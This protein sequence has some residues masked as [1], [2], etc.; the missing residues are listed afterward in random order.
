MD[1]D[2]PLWCLRAGPPIAEVRLDLVPAGELVID[3]SDDGRTY[4]SAIGGASPS[5]FRSC[6]RCRSIAKVGPT[7]E[8]ACMS[9]E[10]AGRPYYVADSGHLQREGRIVHWWR[11]G[12]YLGYTQARTMAI[13]LGCLAREYHRVRLVDKTR[14]L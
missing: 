5:T 4:L 2:D 13:A 10:W 7:V 12:Y 6:F 14:L 1:L 3:V 8:D 11:D 9:R